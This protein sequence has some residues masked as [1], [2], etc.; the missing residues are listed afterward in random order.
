MPRS[1]TRNP[2]TAS[3]WRS[4]WRPVRRWALA[5]TGVLGLGLLAWAAWAFYLTGTPAFRRLPAD[6]ATAGGLDALHQRYTERT[7][8]Q[9]LLVLPRST[10]DSLLGRHR[11][12]DPADVAPPAL[13]Q[14]AADRFVDQVNSNHSAVVLAYRVNAL[15]TL[16]ATFGGWWYLQSPDEQ[17]LSLGNLAAAWRQYLR[18]NFGDWDSPESFAPGIVVVDVSG[19]AAQDLNGTTTIFRRPILP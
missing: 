2:P 16:T 18:D 10:R 1:V 4:P 11:R 17:M 13:V 6:P 5:S 3:G 19:K 8:L 9:A 14:R 15:G 7:Q 12:P